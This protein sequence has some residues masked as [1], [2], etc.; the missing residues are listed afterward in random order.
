LGSRFSAAATVTPTSIASS[1]YPSP[2]DSANNVRTI[3]ADDSNVSAA[4]TSANTF[5]NPNPSNNAYVASATAC[6]STTN[7]ASLA[8]FAS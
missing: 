8:V 6:T 5:A 1:T 4:T 2:A 3:C 7:F